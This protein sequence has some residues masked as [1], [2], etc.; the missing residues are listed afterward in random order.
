[1]EEDLDKE[2]VDQLNQGCECLRSEIDII[3]RALH[4]VP[5][6]K[7]EDEYVK[8]RIKKLNGLKNQFKDLGNFFYK[9]CS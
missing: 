3:L 1:M 2:I 6:E 7:L 5:L 4:Q 8:N 9:K